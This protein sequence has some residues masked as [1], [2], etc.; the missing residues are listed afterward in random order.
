MS[1]IKFRRLDESL[2]YEGAVMAI[3]LIRSSMNSEMYFVFVST[4]E[5]IG[6][7][8]WLGLCTYISM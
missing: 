1:L 4:P 5:I 7:P 2:M 3:L 8:R 6:L